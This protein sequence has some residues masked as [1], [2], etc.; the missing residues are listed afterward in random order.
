[1]ADG[2]PVVKSVLFRVR[3]HAV[4]ALGLSLT[5]EI[6]LKEAALDLLAVHLDQRLLGTLVRLVLNVGESLRL[7]RLPVVCDTDRFDL[8]EPA[9]P[10]TDVIFL[11]VVGQTFDEKGVALGGH[12]LGHLSTL[13]RLCSLTTLG[14]LD[15]EIAAPQT[16]PVHR[17]GRLV[18]LLSLE[19]DMGVPDA[20]ARVLKD[21][22]L[23]LRDARLGLLAK[24][25]NKLVF[26]R[27]VR[28]PRNEELLRLPLLH[29]R[30]ALFL[31]L[32]RLF[33]F[34]LFGDLLGHLSVELGGSRLSI[35]LFLS[36]LFVLLLRFLF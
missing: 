17:Q 26:R 8:S 2:L 14:F 24:E 16:L 29:L 31:F 4:A 36:A 21:R 13:R 12:R 11:K 27:V 7:L 19:H 28:D 32:G 15:V 5:V 23:D 3:V 30:L 25:S 33:R 10:I 20:L 9:E 1:L 22:H 18:S 35:A 6:N 34:G